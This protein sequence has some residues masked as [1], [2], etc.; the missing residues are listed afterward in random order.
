MALNNMQDLDLQDLALAQIG[1]G[2]GALGTIGGLTGATK[3]PG[4]NTFMG[5]AGTGLGLA[6]QFGLKMDLQDLGKNYAGNYYVM[7]DVNNNKGM[8]LGNTGKDYV[9]F[10]RINNNG[11]VVFTGL[12]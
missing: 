3:N 11:V 9:D 12:I 1:A 5:V 10:G 2:L 4:F 6:G 7:G 8:I